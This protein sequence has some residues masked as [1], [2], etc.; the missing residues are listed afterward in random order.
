[1]VRWCCAKLAS[2]HRFF[3]VSAAA[4]ISAAGMVLWCQSPPGHRQ[5]LAA[6]LLAANEPLCRENVMLKCCL[7]GA[8]LLKRRCCAADA[9]PCSCFF[10][11]ALLHLFA[12]VV[13]VRRGETIWD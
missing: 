1:M 5:R 6:P 8:V 9:S 13:S 12:A 11:V 4:W 7:N 2:Q 10:A 3:A